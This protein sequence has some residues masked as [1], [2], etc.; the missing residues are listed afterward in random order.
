MRDR[1]G[2]VLQRMLI[3]IVAVPAVAPLLVL[4]DRLTARVRRAGVDGD[5][6]FSVVEW[7]LLIA[8]TITI[9]TAVST[10]VIAKLRAKANQLDLTTP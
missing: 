5:A 8:V 7:V 2:A 4:R 9:V 1:V 3:L 10:I 6:G